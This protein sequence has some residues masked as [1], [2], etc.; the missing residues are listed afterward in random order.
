MM[1][2]T[3]L[4]GGGCQ[5]TTK[6]A[7]LECYARYP[8]QCRSAKVQLPRAALAGGGHAQLHRWYVQLVFCHTSVYCFG[9]GIASP[10]LG[11]N[12]II[13]SQFEIPGRTA[14]DIA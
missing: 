6:A 12:Q 1:C 14:A 10:A 9:A 3:N 13:R 11:Q 8:A 2:N 7:R 4:H 5:V